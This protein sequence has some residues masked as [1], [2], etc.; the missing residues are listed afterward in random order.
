VDWEAKRVSALAEHARRA[1][2]PARPGEREDLRLAA[3]AGA[4]W[5]AGLA[6]LMAGRPDE[7]RRS[8]VRA[9]DEYVASWD[10]APDGSWGRPIAALRCRLLAGDTAGARV[11]ARRALSVG[12]SDADGTVAAYCA[13]L[14]LLVLGDDAAAGVVGRSLVADPGFQPAAVAHGLV[15]LATHDAAAYEDAVTAVLRSFVERDA[16]LEDVEVADTVLVLD[17]LA[18]ARG[19]DRPPLDSPLLPASRRAGGET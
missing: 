9:A 13:C 2:R 5:A 16:F 11:D 6:A 19:L 3:V 18:A 12:A 14:A 7:A 4:S 1:A 8:L 10:V 17:A 15:A